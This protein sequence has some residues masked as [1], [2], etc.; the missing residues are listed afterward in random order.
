MKNLQINATS[1][2]GRR[3]NNEDALL[4]SPELGLYAVCDGMGGYAGGE[5]AS[6]TAV[7]VLEHFFHANLK[8]GGITWPYA[9]DRARSLKENMVDVAVRLAHQAILARRKGPLAQMG[10]TVV[11]LA[12]DDDQEVV[13]GHIGDSRIYR[14]RDG[15]LEL[16][17][18]DHS[19]YNECK[20]AGFELP[21]LEEFPHKNIVTRALGIPTSSGESPELRREAFLPGDVFLLCTD[22]LHDVV[23]DARIEELLRSVPFEEVA[24]RLVME[25]YEAGSRDN[26]TCLLLR[27]G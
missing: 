25:A 6:K 15:G 3:Q 2:V 19:M 20:A 13:L 24:D 17:T 11:V 18:V 21:P 14:L 27:R 23:S 7:E 5:V 9:L 12:E 4:E 8:D 16:L 22:G 1:I 10:T 26:I